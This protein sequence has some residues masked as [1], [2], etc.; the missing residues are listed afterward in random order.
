MRT[1]VHLIQDDAEDRKSALAITKNLT[2]DDSVELDAV[3]VVAQGPGIEAVRNDAAVSEH[4]ESLL[5]DGVSITACQ[6]T[7]DMHDLTEA[8]LVDGIQTAPSG[9]GELTRLQSDGYAYIRP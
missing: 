9:V 4:V 6:N 3:A 5:D 7:M 8:D 1:V 2:E